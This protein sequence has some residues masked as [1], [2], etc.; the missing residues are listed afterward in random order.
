M[1]PVRKNWWEPPV[2]CPLTTSTSVTATLREVMESS[3]TAC[4]AW[5]YFLCVHL[6]WQWDY[7]PEPDCTYRSSGSVGYRQPSRATQEA[8]PKARRHGASSITPHGAL[9]W[10]GHDIT[11]WGSGGSEWVL[12]R[13]GSQSVHPH[14]RGS[15]EHPRTSVGIADSP[16]RRTSGST[17]ERA[18]G[19]AL[20][21]DSP[22]LTRIQRKPPMNT[23]QAALTAWRIHG[24]SLSLVRIK[25]FGLS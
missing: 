23:G 13:L 3:H 22:T 9:C 21:F 14:D 10:S 6:G 18:A 2:C 7:H 24:T 8:A 17:H 12:Y 16:F 11:L 20:A 19:K 4:E 1:R 15:R 25:T 5:R